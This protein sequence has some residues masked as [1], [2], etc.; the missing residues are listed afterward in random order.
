MALHGV[1]EIVTTCHPIKRGFVLRDD[2]KTVH[3]GVRGFLT[4]PHKKGE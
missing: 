4:V 3:N 1:M 2:I